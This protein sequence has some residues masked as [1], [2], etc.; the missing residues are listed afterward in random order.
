MVHGDTT[1]RY[2]GGLDVLVQF[3]NKEEA[4]SYLSK[5][6]LWSEWFANL[7]VWEGR[8]VPFE[9]IAWVRIQGVP[10]NL[11]DPFIF[12]QIGGIIG[13]VVHKSEASTEDCN[14]SLDCLGI[15]VSKGDVIQEQV[16]LAW[17]GKHFEC[18]VTEDPRPWAPDFVN[19][20]GSRSCSE[21]SSSIN[22][23]A[24]QRESEGHHSSRGN[25]RPAGNACA[26]EKG[27]FN[28]GTFKFS[29]G[30][31]A[32]NNGGK[33]VHK[34][35]G[36]KSRAQLSTSNVVVEPNN[37]SG[38]GPRP[39]KRSRSEM[40]M[41]G[42]M[43]FRPDLN[44]HPPMSTSSTGFGDNCCELGSVVPNSIESVED[45][46]VDLEEGQI[47]ESHDDEGLQQ[48]V[49]NTIRVAE[50]VG[51]H[52]AG[53]YHEVRAE[54]LGEGGRATLQISN[55]AVFWDLKGGKKA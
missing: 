25:E 29:S 7:Y 8:T 9:R 17:K 48:E 23:P 12:N 18:W 16:T 14:L 21:D 40:S 49:I 30:T 43:T 52:L 54:I 45:G 36:R 38:S 20:S 5:D 34:S 22:P 35:S 3:Q 41:V 55:V 46:D 2:L 44:V 10:P 24:S 50:S 37:V 42:Q 15:L 26:W 39:K 11:W 4:M 6:V 19:V 1:I 13:S 53:K 31:N 27:E 51:I 28:A 33:R 32:N 47:P